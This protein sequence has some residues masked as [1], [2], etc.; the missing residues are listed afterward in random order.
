MSV[1]APKNQINKK[2]TYFDLLVKPNEKQKLEVNVSNTGKKEKTIRVTPTN[3]ITNDN[4]LV[5]YSKQKK[6]YKYDN[7]LEIPFT[8]LVSPS[9]TFKVKP[10]KTE[11]LTFDLQTPEKEFYG[12]ILGGFVADLVDEETESKKED[13]ISFVNKFQLVKAIIIRSSEKEITPDLKINDVKPALVAYRTAVTANIQN[14]TP[15]LL[16]KV[17]IDA[18][19]TKKDDTNILKSVKRDDVEFAPNSNFNFPIMWDNQPLDTGNYTLDMLITVKDKEFKFNEDFRISK[20]ESYNINDKAVDL[21]EESNNTWIWIGVSITFI[22]II[23]ILLFILY[24]EKN[25]KR[26]KKKKNKA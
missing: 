17:K 16:G 3:A 18:K 1:I 9:Q 10:G 19:I 20:E 7:S 2:I 25:K 22:L 15:I 13:N 26:K 4:G 6:N 5:D 21:K 8:T 14:K 11:K 12:I 24:K 23:L